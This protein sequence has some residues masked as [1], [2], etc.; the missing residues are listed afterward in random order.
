MLMLAAAPSLAETFKVESRFRGQPLMIPAQLL[1]PEKRGN[2]KLPAMI[3]M[4]GSGGVR[5]RERSYARE[6]NA[7]GVAAVIIDSFSPRGVKSTVRDQSPVSSYD[8]VVDAVSTLKAVA[9]RTEIDPAR[10][11]M[12]GFS[13]GG[14]VVIKAA[15]RRYVEPLAAGEARFALLIAMYPWCGDLPLD[16]HAASGAPLHMLLG[17]RDIYVGTESCKE[18]GKKYADAGGD[19]ALKI[20]AGAQH[21]WDV[22]GSVHWVVRDGQN[23]SKCI[24]DEIVPGTWVERSS[25][26][27]IVEDNKRTGNLKKALAHCM[28]L[29]VSGGYDASTRARSLEDI[30]AYTRAAF[31]LQ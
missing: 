4:H 25:R 28:T 8:M 21:D 29:G 10:I 19:L 18:F 31:H 12:I 16:F 15:L 11:G 2:G 27:K 6:F 7:L 1:L 14:T 26:I 30:R 3:I 23:Q 5:E 24:Y 13:K 17:E 9:Q 20:Y 22:P